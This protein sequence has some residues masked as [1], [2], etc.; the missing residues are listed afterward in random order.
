VGTVEFLELLYNVPPLYHIN[1]DEFKKHKER[2]KAHYDLFSQLHRELGLLPMT[3]FAWLTPD[4]LIQLTVF[5][6]RV[7]MVANFTMEDFDY[8]GKVIPKRSIMAK[9]RNT[10]ETRI[11]TPATK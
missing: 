1:M 2:M 6:D 5:G 9:W 8:Q 7:E 11:Y 3:D 10:E 4:R